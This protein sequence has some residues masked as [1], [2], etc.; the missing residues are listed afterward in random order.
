MSLPNLPTTIAEIDQMI[1]DE[2]QESLHLDYKDSRAINKNKKEDIAKD[3][4][5][6]ANSDGGLLIY[7]V[8]E[9]DHFPDAIDSGVDFVE[10]KCTREWLE[11]VINSNI[12]PKVDDIRI[13][14]IPLSA[15]RCLYAVSV[16]KSLRGP[17]QASDKKYYRRYNFL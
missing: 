7:G 1:K 3:V 17:H 14:A 10:S 4:S 5:A 6:F 2:V 13:A 16:P 11:Q 8:S 9:K 12:S 15:D